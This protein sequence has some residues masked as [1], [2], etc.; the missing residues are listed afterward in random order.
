MPLDRAPKLDVAVDLE[1][2]AQRLG[3]VVER[4][5]VEAQDDVA[6]PLLG[7]VRADV[8]ACEHLLELVR[9]VP[10]VVVL[11]QRHPAGLP[12]PP[13]PDEDDVALFLQRPQE[14]GLVDVEPAVR[15]DA[16]EARL[17]V[18]DAGP[19]E[20]RIGSRHGRVLV[21]HNLILL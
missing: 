6:V 4:R 7:R 11:E 17:P 15:T 8:R 3:I 21:L 2:F 18:G 1:A 16:P 10:P 12:E 5:E 13:R 20:R 9:P 14:A 19:D